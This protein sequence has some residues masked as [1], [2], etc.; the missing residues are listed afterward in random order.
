MSS[1]IP[2]NQDLSNDTTFS[3]IKSRVPVPLRLKTIGPLVMKLKPKSMVLTLDTVYQSSTSQPTIVYY[4][5]Q[6]YQSLL[7]QSIPCNLPAC[8]TKLPAHIGQTK[9]SKVCRSI[10]S[11]CLLVF[12]P[13][14]QINQ[15]TSL[16]FYQS[17][18][19]PVYNYTSMPLNY[20]L[21]T[22]LLVHQSAIV[23]DVLKGTVS[24]DFL[25]C[26]FYH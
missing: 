12:K 9:E 16:L 8:P 2:T 7:N 20:M 13:G 21:S 5:L 3:K 24:Q 19:L 11:N 26:F 14:L 4:S 17:T 10:P 25:Y 6:I 22:S 23:L 18:I 15:P 1:V